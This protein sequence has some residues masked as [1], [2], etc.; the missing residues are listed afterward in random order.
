MGVGSYPS[1]ATAHTMPPGPS[2]GRPPNENRAT[3]PS[4]SKAK[5]GVVNCDVVPMLTLSILQHE[6]RMLEAPARTA[7]LAKRAASDDGE[8]PLADAFERGLVVEARAREYG[9]QHVFGHGI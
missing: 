8:E 1:V 4:P 7:L 6:D 2:H 3:A 5:I 9:A